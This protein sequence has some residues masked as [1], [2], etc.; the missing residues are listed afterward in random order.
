MSATNADIIIEQG[1]IPVKLTY[2]SDGKASIYNKSIVKLCPDVLMGQILYEFR[3][4]ITNKNK[5]IRSADTT[6]KGEEGLF[7][8][9]S[10]T[11]VL[12]L[13]NSS[14]KNNYDK[15]KETDKF[16]YLE[17]HKESIFGAPSNAPLL[18]HA[19]LSDQDPGWFWCSFIHGWIS[20]VSFI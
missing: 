5:I 13:S 14:L 15:Y 10:K 2:F 11:A 3:C 9:I 18:K 12:P 7:L 19:L 16:L 17:I 1:F 20:Q 4:K 8:M 6:L